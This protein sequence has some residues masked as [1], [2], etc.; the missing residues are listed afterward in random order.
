MVSQKAMRDSKSLQYSVRDSWSRWYLL[1]MQNLEISKISASTA[2]KSNQ[3]VLNWNHE[4]LGQV[5]NPCLEEMGPLKWHLQWQMTPPNRETIRRSTAQDIGRIESYSLTAK[6]PVGTDNQ[7][8]DEKQRQNDKTGLGMEKTVKDKA[9]S[10]PESQSSQKVN[11]KFE[12][13]NF[14]L[15][16]TDALLTLDYSIPPEIDKGVFDPEGDIL[17]LEK[18]LNDE[19]LKDLPPKELK[20][21]EIKTTKSLIEEPPES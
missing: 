4:H 20:D 5:M 9:K 13:I 15:E 10:K 1:K 21:D 6:E 18:L 7:E 12:R 19:I 2:C 14:L 11:R 8:K 16:E 3:V 17:L